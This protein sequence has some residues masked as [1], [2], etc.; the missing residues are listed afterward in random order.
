MEETSQSKRPRLTSED[1]QEVNMAT[2]DVHGAGTKIRRPKEP[3]NGYSGFEEQPTKGEVF[4]WYLYEMCSYFILTVLIPIVFPLIISQTVAQPPEPLTGWSKTHKGLAC[5]PKEMQLYEALTH[6]SIVIN[7]SKLSPLDWTSISWAIGIIVA[8]PILSFISVPLDYGTNQQ[9]VAGAATAVGTFF[10]LPTGFF[11]T[12]WIFPL[13][14]MAIVAANIITTAAHTRHLGFMVRG[15]V[16]S[17]IQ[18]NKFPS[19]R[20]VA[21]WLSLYATAAGC[22]GSALV[23]SFT[24]Q[25]LHHSEKFIS[26]WVVSIFTGLIWLIGMSHVFAVYRPGASISSR[27]S[28]RAHLFS[29]FKYRH[30]IGSLAAVFLSSFA[31]MCIFA[32]AVLFLVGQQCIKPIHVLYFWLMYFLFPVFS[33]PLL[34]PVQQFIKADAVRMQLLGFLL[35]MITSGSGFYFR[36]KNWHG[37]HIF[38]FAAIQSTATG[39][40]HAFGRVLLMDCSPAGKEGVFSAWFSWVRSVGLFAGFTFALAV[41]HDVGRSFGIGFLCATLGIIALIFGNVD[42]FGGAVAAGTVRDDGEKGSPVHGLDNGGRG[43][44]KGTLQT[45]AKMEV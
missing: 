16:G 15:Y 20:A 7:G 3:Y 14:I 45:I 38:L 40:L 36:K 32:G 24:Y 13:Y 18:K 11:K 31:T 33:L 5:R 8:G 1:G 22:L 41:P 23:S 44:T 26:L 39:L 21:S 30:A 27:P 37:A 35:S 9:L 34:H 4:L 10:C 43:E 6:R 28:T 17:V 29:I 42:N 19:R 12:R 25:M 2:P